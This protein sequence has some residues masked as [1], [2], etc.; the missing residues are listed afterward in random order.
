MP[1]TVQTAPQY[2]SCNSACL[3]SPNPFLLTD[4]NGMAREQGWEGRTRS[5]ITQRTRTEHLDRPAL[6]PP[7][8]LRM[9]LHPWATGNRQSS[10]MSLCGADCDTLRYA[11]VQGPPHSYHSKNRPRR[12]S[13]CGTDVCLSWD[14]ESEN[15]PL[16]HRQLCAEVTLTETKYFK[17]TS[18]PLC[19]EQFSIMF[20]LKA[21]FLGQNSKTFFFYMAGQLSPLSRDGAWLEAEAQTSRESH[22]GQQTPS[23]SAEQLARH[24]HTFAPLGFLA[25]GGMKFT[26]VHFP[27]LYSLRC[28]C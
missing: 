21:G 17:D 2:R 4:V 5:A 3:S 27:G 9:A 6:V 10:A 25:Y 13:H 11:C 1:V 22:L 15:T 12:S 28:L 7:L 14:R 23:P 24:R 8:L 20:S 18:L 16:P 26:S 19:G